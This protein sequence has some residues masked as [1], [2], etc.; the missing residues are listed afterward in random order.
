M[1]KKVSS[2]IQ[3]LKEYNK[4]TGS[5]CLPKKGSEGYIKVKAISDRIK[6]DKNFEKAPDLRKLKTEKKVPSVP[7]AP[8]LR[9]L[10]SSKVPKAP[11]LR[12]LQK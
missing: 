7:K 8:D 6:K 3:A 11:D 5:W 10:Q 1:S 2:W 4:D 12:K 9:K